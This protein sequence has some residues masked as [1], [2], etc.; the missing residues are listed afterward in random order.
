MD[1]WPIFFL[2]LTVL[3]DSELPVCQ[4]C[5][6]QGV[7]RGPF[8]GSPQNVFLLEALWVT[9]LFVYLLL[10]SPRTSRSL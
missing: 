1:T 8:Q 6:S 7:L 5:P 2:L 10:W 3:A 4:P 9:H